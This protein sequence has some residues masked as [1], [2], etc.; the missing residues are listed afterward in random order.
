[1]AFLEIVIVTRLSRGHHAGAVRLLMKDCGFLP[2][3]PLGGNRHQRTGWVREEF[4]KTSA[5]YGRIACGADGTQEA[6]APRRRGDSP[7]EIVR[8]PGL[9]KGIHHL[10]QL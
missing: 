4:R 5:A 8:R 7:V 6:A 3:R 1:M 9:R 10:H 2:E